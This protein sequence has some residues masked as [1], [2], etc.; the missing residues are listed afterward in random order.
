M[1]NK[2]TYLVDGNFYL[3]KTLSVC[4]AFDEQHPMFLKGD[5]PE[6]MEKDKNSL[7]HKLTMDFC[8]DIRK[9]AALIDEVIITMDDYSWRNDFFENKS[10]KYATVI[11]STEEGDDLKEILGGDENIDYKGHRVKEKTFNWTL[12]YQTFEE[13]LVDMRTI[14]GI[15]W[16]RLNGC[17]GDD[18]IFAVATQYIARGKSVMIYSGDNDL[19]QLISFNSMNNSFVIHFKKTEKKIVMS[20]DTATWLM[21]N[22][23]LIKTKLTNFAHENDLE[24]LAENAFDIVFTKILKGDKGDNVKPSIQEVR[25]YKSGKKKGEDKLEKIGKR[26]IDKIKVEIDYKRYNFLDFFNDDFL[27]TLTN[28][29]LRNFKPIHHFSPENIKNNLEINR[30]LMFLHKNCIPHS[31]YEVMITWI[32]QNEKEMDLKIRDL[33]SYKSVLE[34]NPHYTHKPENDTTSANIFKLIGL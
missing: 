30:D 7:I 32:E 33:Y 5:S 13:F 26:V 19:K 15:K 27:N 1:S 8:S 6:K 9:A 23:S 10:Y 34:R 21:G 24:L 25:K 4:G 14:G 16:S 3:H 12:V 31:I 11:E 18:I 22:E 2:I 20:N 29:V 17:E 28:S